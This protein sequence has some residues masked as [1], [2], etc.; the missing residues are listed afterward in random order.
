[1]PL[2][3][4]RAK[5]KEKIDT[6]KGTSKS[7]VEVYEAH[8]TDLIGYPCVTFDISDTDEDFASTAEND[9]KIV[10]DIYVHVNVER[11]PWG[12]TNATRMIDSILDELL[13]DF[14]ADYNLGGTVDYCKPSAT[15]R[16]EYQE[17][18]G[19]VKFGKMKLECHKL[20]T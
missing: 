19:F 7:L 20:I 4:L 6:H 8:E 5:I 11:R 18:I 13:A 12:M 14:R 2:V 17:A 1:M 15:S 3:T 16:G 10:F 9:E